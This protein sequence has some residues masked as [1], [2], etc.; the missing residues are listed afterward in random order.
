MWSIVIA[1]IEAK[2]LKI[3][4]HKVEIVL[5]VVE[6]KARV[7]AVVKIA[8]GRIRRL[9]VIVIAGVR[10]EQPAIEQILVKKIPEIHFILI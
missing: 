9:A 10:A 4:I 5:I 3:I 8:V 2:L 1:F 6:T 7:H